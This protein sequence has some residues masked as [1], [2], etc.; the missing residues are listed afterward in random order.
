MRVYRWD[1]NDGHV[2]EIT[3]GEKPY[4]DGTGSAY[5]HASIWIPTSDYRREQVHIT[6]TPNRRKAVVESGRA[7]LAC[8]GME[9]M[10]DT[11]VLHV[12]VPREGEHL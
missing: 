2:L 5:R 10:G 1:T 7:T 6:I 4:N 9:T 11:P 12:V 8:I 3:A